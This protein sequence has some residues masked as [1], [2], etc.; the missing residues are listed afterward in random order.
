MIF[1]WIENCKQ[2]I[3]T[4]HFPNEDGYEK[5][6]QY[7]QHLVLFNYLVEQQNM[8][9]E[10][11]KEFWLTTD[12]IYLT[13]AL[14]TLEDERDGWVNAQFNK[15]WNQ[16]TQTNINL[17]NEY[18]HKNYD[19]PIYQEE[20]NYINSL[21]CSTWLKKA[22]LLLLSCAKHSENNLVKYNNMT[23]SWIARMIDPNYR[24]DNKM[25]KIGQVN[26]KYNLFTFV[27]FGNKGNRIKINFLKDSGTTVAIVHSP[28]QM[29]DVL[30]LIAED[31]KICPNCG[32][33]FTP[34]PKQQT[35]LCKECYLLKRKQ[36]KLNY[37]HKVRE[38]QFVDS[39]M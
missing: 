18:N 13:N 5:K 9:K 29:G 14:N 7:Y 27:R 20:L 10:E 19:Y 3:K 23:T 21:D 2:I 1:D 26:C 28:N 24:V 16:R 17:K 22:F 38:K 31:T 35:N 30:N 32:K 33:V 37:I 39:K 36:D 12:S 8:S 4:K 25:L 6:T 15:L 11:V 34:S